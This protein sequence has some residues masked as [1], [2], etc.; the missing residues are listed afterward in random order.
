MRAQVIADDVNGS[1]WSLTGDEILQ[2]GDEL[3][4]G[5]AGTGLADNLAAPGI[6]GCIERERSMAIIFKAVSFSPAGR[7]RQHWV[8]TIQCLDGTLFVDAEYCGVERGLEVQADHIGRLLF[9]LRIGA[10]HIAAYPMGLDSSPGPY[11]SHSAMGNAQ[12]L[13]QPSGAPM[14]RAIGGAC[15]VA[16]RILAS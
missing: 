7:Q 12:M 9:K 6:K 3:C 13:S 14:S 1:F 5:V 11:S 2:K 8:Q 4:T 16:F 10:R 15:L